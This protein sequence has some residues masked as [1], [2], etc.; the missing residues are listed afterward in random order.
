MPTPPR[1]TWGIGVEI[2]PFDLGADSLDPDYPETVDSNIILDELD[3][4]ISDWRELAQ[5]FKFTG[6]QNGTFYVNGAHNPADAV[7]LTIRSI[8]EARFAIDA[9]VEFDFELGNDRAYCTLRIRVI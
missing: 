1:V 3:L 8:G 4:K 9:L 5:T 2:E 7:E 6:N